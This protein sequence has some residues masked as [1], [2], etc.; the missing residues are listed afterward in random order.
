MLVTWCKDADAD[1]YGDP[2]TEVDACSSPGAGYV[3]KSS[4][5]RACEDCNDANKLVHPN[6]THCDGAGYPVGGGK[7]SFDFNC[8]DKELACHDFKK[9][10]ANGCTL[11]TTGGSVG[12]SGS[13]YLKTGRTGSGVDPYCGSDQWLNCQVS[14][15]PGSLICSSSVVLYNPVTCK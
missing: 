1:E 15:D 5:P 10:A 2:A 4:K 14:G 9:A 8:D 6:S 13:G 11:D 7:V 3:K 12:C